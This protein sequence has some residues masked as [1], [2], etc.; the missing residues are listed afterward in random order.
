MDA[1]EL[2]LRSAEKINKNGQDNL[3]AATEMCKQAIALDPNYCRAHGYLA[4]SIQRRVYQGWSADQSA[5]IELALSHA[6]IAILIDPGDYLAHASLGWLLLQKGDYT[7]ALNELETAANINPIDAGVCIGLST[8]LLANREFD[9]ALEITDLAIRR[10]PHDPGNWALL[11]YKAGAYRNLGMIK[12]AISTF[13][14]SSRSPSAGLNVFLGLA[15][16]HMSND[17]PEEAKAAIARAREIQPKLSIEFLA[18]T[19]L[20]NTLSHPAREEY[21]MNLRAAGLPERLT[22]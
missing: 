9:R 22:E 6:N 20:V 1:W 10:S 16:S 2:V 12:K 7:S 4:D 3:L 5:D 19:P 21:F 17:Q 18:K 15:I 14:E 11:A 13:Q 8:A